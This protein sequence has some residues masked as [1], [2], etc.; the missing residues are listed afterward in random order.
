SPPAAQSA[1]PVPAPDAEA[2][3]AG[4]RERVQSR[5]GVPARRETTQP[6]GAAQEQYPEPEHYE[7]P[8][9]R[10]LPPPDP[11]H[12][13]PEPQHPAAYEHEV[14]QAPAFE[15]APYEPQVLH[16][17]PYQPAQA[18]NYADHARPAYELQP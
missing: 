2:I 9:Q 7:P 13:E 3:L 17:A 10:A 11:T 1:R 12:Y 8:A 4:A 18:D 6:P 5:I 15:Q 16:E 14:E